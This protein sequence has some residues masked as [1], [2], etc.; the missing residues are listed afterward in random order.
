MDRHFCT[1]HKL[2]PEI[3]FGYRT[4]FQRHKVR[5]Q[6]DRSALLLRL[7]KHPSGAGPSL[8]V[9]RYQQ[10]P[11]PWNVHFPENQQQARNGFGGQNNAIV[12][13]RHF[14]RIRSMEKYQNRFGRIKSRPPVVA[15]TDLPF[16]FKSHGKS[17]ISNRLFYVL[18][19]EPV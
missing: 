5:Q 3:R 10:A 7:L 9:P 4:A 19:G 11:F 8:P 13:S 2:M 6:S 17:F 15:K 1:T 16:Y 18:F 14:D 12:D